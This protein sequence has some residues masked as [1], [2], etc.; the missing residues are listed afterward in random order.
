M[1]KTLNMDMVITSLEA[2][3]EL[4]AI[5]WGKQ[6][7]CFVTTKIDMG[8]LKQNEVLK[9]FMRKK[10]IENF[11]KVDINELKDFINENHII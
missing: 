3:K 7:F 1:K 2:L 9:D 6:S 5:V 10:E 4:D 11:S 8:E